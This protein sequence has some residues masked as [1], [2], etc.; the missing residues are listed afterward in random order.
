MKVT[1]VSLPQV[2]EGQRE[3]SSLF[4]EPSLEL[5]LYYSEDQEVLSLAA[6][7][8]QGQPSA[9]PLSGSPVMPWQLSAAVVFFVSLAGE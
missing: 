6:V 4:L 5:T 2:N 9:R 7:Q 8:Q 3:V 1:L